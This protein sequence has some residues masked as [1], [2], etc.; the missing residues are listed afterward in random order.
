MLFPFKRVLFKYCALDLNMQKDINIVNQVARNLEL[1][2]DLEIMVGL[3]CI[4]PLLEGLNKLIK[5]SQSQ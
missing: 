1:F 3:S 4:M 2:C 5:F